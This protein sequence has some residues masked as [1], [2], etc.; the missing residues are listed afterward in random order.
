[1]EENEE[2]ESKK[3]KRKQKY[4][5]RD[6]GISGEGEVQIETLEGHAVHQKRSRI[7]LT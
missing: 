5:E 7:N 3:K 6:G 1:M 4:H 2:F